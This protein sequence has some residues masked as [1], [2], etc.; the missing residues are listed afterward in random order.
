MCVMLRD[1]GLTIVVTPLVALM[2]D[3]LANLPKAIRGA[4]INSHQTPEQ[5]RKGLSRLS[6]LLSRLLG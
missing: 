1:E 5:S 6:G 3:Q 2:A 4:C